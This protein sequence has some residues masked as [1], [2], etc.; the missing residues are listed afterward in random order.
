MTK[1][2]I[3]LTPGQR[4]ALARMLEDRVEIIADDIAN[5]PASL[6][7]EGQFAAYAEIAEILALMGII[8]QEAKSRIAGV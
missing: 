8:S 4:D 3:S 2:A 1:H 5:T 6:F 7:A